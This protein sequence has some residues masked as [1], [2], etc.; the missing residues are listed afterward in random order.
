MSLDGNR[1]VIFE[2][3]VQHVYV[4]GYISSFDDGY[5]WRSIIVNQ[6]FLEKQFINYNDVLICLINFSGF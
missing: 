5:Y 3:D 4:F 1:L 6:I 2:D